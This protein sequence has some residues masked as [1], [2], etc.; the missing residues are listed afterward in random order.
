[1][2]YAVSLDRVIAFLKSPLFRWVAA[3]LLIATLWWRGSHYEADR[4]RWQAAFKAQKAAT[5]AIAEE[6]RAKAEAARIHT[7]RRYAQLA[8][9]ADAGARSADLHA[10][11]RRY[12]DAH[13][14]RPETDRPARS[15]TTATGE[16]DP[17][18]GGDGPGQA[19]EFL[20]VTRNDFDLLVAN[21][22]RLEQVHRW[23]QS[24]IRDNLAMPLP[25]FGQEHP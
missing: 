21:S 15:G 3:T 10:A 9:D 23:G 17:A 4:D 20:V 22:I 7:E 5:V 2:P 13:R 1:M 11:A 14:L 16:G 19:T 6:A 12:A 8:R 25:D 24:L 18:G